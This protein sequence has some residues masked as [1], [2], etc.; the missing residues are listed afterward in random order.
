MR[1]VRP[2]HSRD[3][4]VYLRRMSFS[5]DTSGTLNS[6]PKAIFDVDGMI[7]ETTPTYLSASDIDRLVVLERN[8]AISRYGPKGVGGVI[9]VNTSGK[10]R[11]DEM[12]V[13]RKYDN[14]A[15]QDSLANLISQKSSYVPNTPYY[16]EAFGSATSLT[17]ASDLLNKS[18]EHFTDQPNFFLDLAYY[19][20]GRWNDGKNADMLLAEVLR[21]FPNNIPSLRS[22]AYRYETLGRHDQA[23]EVF[24]QVLKL[25]SLT[26]QSYGDLANAYAA[27]GNREKAL[28]MYRNYGE[29]RDQHSALDSKRAT[30]FMLI[31]SENIKRPLNQPLDVENLGNTTGKNIT[32]TRI[33]ASWSH[34]NTHLDM[35]L[36]SPESLYQIWEAST[37]D[38]SDNIVKFNTS[39]FFV[40]EEPKGEWQLNLRRFEGDPTYLRIMVYFDYGLPTQKM[41][42][43]LFKLT[44][45]YDGTHLLAL[46]TQTRTLG[47]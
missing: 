34:P 32:P 10:N 27:L 19:F 12:G 20:R 15:M 37:L 7:F 6:A 29:I 17:E 46:D 39:Q 23:L 36:I 35:Q 9:I 14:S 44:P 13:V 33:V 30:T 16:L 11:L 8:A 38:S 31:E 18:I 25:D 22:L 43:R 45:N 5:V 1:V 28:E 42:I 3:T 24:Q 2:P 40:E 47:E 26:P 21:R 4:E 41:K